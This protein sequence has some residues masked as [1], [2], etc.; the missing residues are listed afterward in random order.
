MK[1]APLIMSTTRPARTATDEVE[2]QPPRRLVV[3][4][5]RR[6]ASDLAWLV[7]EEEVNKTTAVNRALQVYRILIEAQHNGGEVLVAD[8]AKGTRELRVVA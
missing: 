8:P 4:L 1:G 5:G 2:V 6:A 3:E 7:H